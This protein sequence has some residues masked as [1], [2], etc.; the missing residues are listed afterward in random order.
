MKTCSACKTLKST[1]EFPKSKQTKDG[2]YSWCK[3]CSRQRKYESKLRDKERNP[4][5]YRAKWKKYQ[6]TY[7]QRNPEKH[8]A[9]ERRRGLRKF[10]I[11]PED[12]DRMFESRSGLCEI[13][14]MT[15][16]KRLAVD[17]DH[18]TGEVRGLLCGSCNMA[19]GQLEERITQ[20]LEYIQRY[21]K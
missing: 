17:H 16:D 7:K 3:I 12:Y 2:L 4:E 10:G 15:S 11:T 13:C 6:T 5:E 14:G 1:D 20:T 9:A 21:K 8:Q 19:L 18:V